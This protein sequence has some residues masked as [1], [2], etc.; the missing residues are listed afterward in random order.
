M[1]DEVKHEMYYKLWEFH[2]NL[3]WSKIQHI[4][5]IFAAVFTGWFI[6]LRMSLEAERYN[7]LYLGINCL[8]CIFGCLICHYLRKLADRDIAHQ[9]HYELK[10]SKIFEGIK[11][12]KDT[13]SQRGRTIFR[14]ILRLCLVSCMVL[15]GIAVAVFILNNFI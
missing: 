8:L 4:L 5:T 7:W 13:S 9:A 1:N 6:L 15:A 3:L 10:L 12:P 11:S 2:A 14:R